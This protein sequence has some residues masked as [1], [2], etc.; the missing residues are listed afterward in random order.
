MITA[1]A[2]V[3]SVFALRLLELVD[4]QATIAVFSG[5]AGYVLGGVLTNPK[6]PI[7]S[8][9]TGRLDRRA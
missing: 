8:G 7:W 6:R 9:T 1:G 2:V 5:I 3:L 4:G